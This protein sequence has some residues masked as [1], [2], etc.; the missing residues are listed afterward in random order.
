MLSPH[1]CM[2]AIIT[3]AIITSVCST[4]SCPMILLS[5]FL[6]QLIWPFLAARS[7]R[8]IDD[9]YKRWYCKRGYCSCSPPIPPSIHPY[10]YPSI[11]VSIYP[12]TQPFGWKGSQHCSSYDLPICVT[13]TPMHPIIY[14]SIPI[15]ST[16]YPSSHQCYLSIH[17]ALWV[18][19]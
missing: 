12:S 8:W 10:T 3:Y 11:Q 17:L 19:I 1:L 7:D 13:K 15:H 14:L 18:G 16:I 5:S 4:K 6:L 2:H 9:N